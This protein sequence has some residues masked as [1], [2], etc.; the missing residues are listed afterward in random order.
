[1]LSEDAHAPSCQWFHITLLIHRCN[2]ETH[3][4]NVIG[5]NQSSFLA[6]DTNTDGNITKE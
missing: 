4:L 5:A 1:M 2:A 3:A 6:D